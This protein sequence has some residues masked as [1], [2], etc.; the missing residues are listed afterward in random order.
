M[1]NAAGSVIKQ[2]KAP[3]SS[4]ATGFPDTAAIKGKFQID[5]CSLPGGVCYLLIVDEQGRMESKKVAKK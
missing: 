2:S 4:V 5:M 1:V 3:S